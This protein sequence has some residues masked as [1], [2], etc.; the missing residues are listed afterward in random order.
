MGRVHT[1]AP[2]LRRAISSRRVLPV[3][4]CGAGKH[5]LHQLSPRIPPRAFQSNYA[6]SKGGLVLLMK[7]LA[8]ELASAGIRVNPLHPAP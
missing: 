6:A 5:N 4:T 7:S 8:Q 2:K 3:G 1:C